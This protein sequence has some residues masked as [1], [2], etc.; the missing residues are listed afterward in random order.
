MPERPV[1]SIYDRDVPT[2][3]ARVAVF[4]NPIGLDVED[5]RPETDRRVAGL[6]KRGLPYPFAG[7]RQTMKTRT[8]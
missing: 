3:I 4:I 1:R 2:E 6:R 8:P 7:G 5:D